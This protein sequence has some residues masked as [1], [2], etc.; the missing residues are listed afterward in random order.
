MTPTNSLPRSSLL[1]RVCSFLA[2]AACLSPLS[3]QTT[4]DASTSPTASSAS[5]DA[6]PKKEDAVLLSKFSVS[7]T[8]DKGYTS[9]NAATGFKTNDDLMKIPQAVTVVTRDLINDIGAVDGSNI[10]RYAGVGNFFAGESFALRG[11]RINYPLLDEMPDGIPYADNINIDSYTVIRGPA[12]TLYLNAA[13]G[14]TVIMNSKFPLQNPAYTFTAKVTD[15]GQYRFETDLTG[16]LG[17]IGDA[18]FSYRVVAGMQDGNSYFRNIVD[19]RQLLHPTLQM[20]WKNTIV[21]FGFDHQVINHV[22]GGNSFITP[23]G[24]LYTGAGR[25]E[26]YYPK[27]GL[28]NFHRDGFRAFIIQKLSDNWDLRLSH[29]SWD[30]SRYGSIVFGSGGINWPAQ[31]IT[32]NSRKNDQKTRDHTTLLDVNG[33]YDVHGVSLNSTFGA[34]YEQGHT[35]TRILAFAPGIFTPITLPIASNAID[36]IIAPDPSN[37]TAGT[38]TGS[39]IYKTN[40]YFQETIGFFR[41]RLTLV[42]GITSSEIKT[43]NIANLN[44]GAAGVGVKGKE[45]LHR[46]GVVVKII[47]ELSAYAME[48][49]TFTPTSQRDINLNLLPASEG[50]AREAGL[51]ADFF[52]GHLS[53]TAAV[54]RIELSNQSYNAGVRSDGISYFA[55]VG[56]TVQKGFDLDLAYSPIQGLQFVGAYYQGKVRAYRGDINYYP[57]VDG[58]N[59]PNSYSSQYSLVGRYEVQTGA[60]KGLSFGSG[61]TCLE[62][63]KLAPGVYVGGPDRAPMGTIKSTG[64]VV[65]NTAVFRV[66]P[67]HE[68]SLFASYQLNQHWLFRVNVD[69][70]LNEAYVLGAQGAY[71][72]DPS[73]PRTFSFSSV[74]RF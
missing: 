33:K 38:P 70:V 57:G 37:P 20:A 51:K 2:A 39:Q 13:L 56:S 53:A 59:V 17:N 16:P 74:Y 9:T 67:S 24:K 49:T 64:A 23:D 25:D 32:F 69:N 12:A 19:H 26:G 71:F 41:D 65:Q 54:F 45:N 40:F 30:I 10:L 48:S 61:F 68:W 66:Q 73:L 47:K 5:M 14:G 60:A 7:S 1:L 36:N 52:G 6:P 15:Y 3:A 22:S 4:S 35:E 50:K 44:T 42:G 31:T 55:P 28:E 46:Y 8:Q 29:M 21:R 18:K 62:G 63:R 58:D 11:T 34:A 72:V 43:D 27:N